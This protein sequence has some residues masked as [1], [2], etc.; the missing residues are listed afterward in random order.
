MDNKSGRA[1]VVAQK[2]RHELLEYAIAAAYLYV[3][4]G[5]LL[6]YMTA[7]LQAEGT[8]YLPYGV[9]AIKALILGKFILLGNAAGLGDRFASRRP[10]Y[11]II[12]KTLLFL[13]ML[14]I[15][16]VIEEVVVGLI[17]GRPLDASLASVGGSTLLQLLATSA[18]MMLILVPYMAFRELNEVLGEG[19]L[20]RVLREPRAGHR[21]P[22]GASE[23][24]TAADHR[25]V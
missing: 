14:F 3:C 11:V 13:L 24:S 4:F 17:H 12:H 5:A 16:S 15:L 7:I 21:A 2:L 9:A 23:Q 6:L 25:S 8:S 1:T 10:I 22:A 20:W 19:R 18:V